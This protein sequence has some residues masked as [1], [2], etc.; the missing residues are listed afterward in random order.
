MGL[1]QHKISCVS[2]KYA[3]SFCV[4]KRWNMMHCK[5]IEILC[6]YM[7]WWWLRFL[8]RKCHDWVRT[9]ILRISMFDRTRRIVEPEILNQSFKDAGEI[10]RRRNET[11]N[12]Y[13]PLHDYH[14]GPVKRELLT[15]T[16]NTAEETVK[17]VRKHFITRIH[18]KNEGFSYF[19]KYCLWT[20]NTENFSRNIEMT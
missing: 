2:K 6:S 14:H 1:D 9:E 10:L 11:E 17:R 4:P 20:T 15:S 16:R 12:F 5:D 13:N 3:Q 7:S 19:K 18:L 8:A